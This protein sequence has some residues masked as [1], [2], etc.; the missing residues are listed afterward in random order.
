MTAVRD[1]ATALADPTSVELANAMLTAALPLLG[2]A[3]ETEK[4][5]CK[6]RLTQYT[7]LTYVNELRKQKRSRLA[8]ET[9]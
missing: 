5:K 9:E 6:R 7:W 4:T 2:I 3:E 1:A 8:E